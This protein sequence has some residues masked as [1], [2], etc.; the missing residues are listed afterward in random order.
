MK[1]EWRDIEGYEGIYQISNYGRVKAVD[2]LINDSYG[3]IWLRKGQI[4]STHID[5]FGYEKVILCKN[6]TQ[7]HFFIHRLVAMAFVSNPDNFPLINH[8]DEDKLN[9]RVENLEWCTPRYN[10]NYGSRN[11]KLS[12]KLKLI[13]TGKPI[14]QYSLNGI[15]LRIYKNAE[16]AARQNSFWRTNISACCRGVKKTAH[17]YKWKFVNTGEK[18]EVGSQLSLF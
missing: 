18:L 13:K 4:R 10:S 2:R 17:G 3:R 15:L 16:E 8:I 9:N 12:A 7:K 6:N 5:R 14:A 11:K 1:E